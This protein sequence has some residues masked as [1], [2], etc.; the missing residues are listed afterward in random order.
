MIIDEETNKLIREL[1]GLSK[2]DFNSLLKDA[3]K[4]QIELKKKKKFAL[5]AKN[6]AA[7]TVTFK[8][9]PTNSIKRE[10]FNRDKV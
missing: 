2:G 7:A 9:T 5:T 8:R 3:L 1:K 10:V 4:T 6:A